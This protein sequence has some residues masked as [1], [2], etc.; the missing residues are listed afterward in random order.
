MSSS[1]HHF[2][3]S[4]VHQF[5][6]S[7]V[8][9]LI[10]LPFLPRGRGFLAASGV[11]FV[12]DSADQGRLEEAKRTLLEVVDHEHLKGVPW[13]CRARGDGTTVVPLPG[14]SHKNPL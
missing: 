12:V 6:R 5:I 4:S 7:S 14:E 10:I 3:S 2:I 11:M 13:P 9:Q 8:H 1:L